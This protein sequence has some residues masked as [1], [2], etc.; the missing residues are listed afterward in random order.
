MKDRR[1]DGKGGYA[2][3][4][5]GGC[6]QYYTEIRLKSQ[7]GGDIDFIVTIYAEKMVNNGWVGPYRPP[8]GPYPAGPYPSGPVFPNQQLPPS[9]WY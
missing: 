9:Q 8:S 7:T 6:T 4:L 3:V 1:Q 5:K 2:K